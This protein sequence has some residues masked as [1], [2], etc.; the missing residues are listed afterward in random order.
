MDYWQ[1]RLNILS[2]VER[3]WT[4]FEMV[5]RFSVHLKL[6]ITV[7]CNTAQITATH[8][9]LVILL[10]PPLSV[11]WLQLSKKDYSLRPC[12]SWT[13][14]VKRRSNIVFLSPWLPPEDPGPPSSEYLKVTLLLALYSTGLQPEVRIPLEIRDDIVVGKRKHHTEYVKLKNLFRDKRWT[15]RKRFRASHRRPWR[16][17]IKFT[18]KKNHINNW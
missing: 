16:E 17:D 2:R 6:G 4:E 15:I 1:S 14:I 7:N 8:T 13:L 9:S 5:I 10:Q 11:A 18:G 12:G 3:L